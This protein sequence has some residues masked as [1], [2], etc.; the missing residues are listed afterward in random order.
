MKIL[1][2]GFLLLVPILFLFV[3][4]AFSSINDMV[5]PSD[6]KILGLTYKQW[7]PK[8]WQ[9][10]VSLPNLKNATSP[11]GET[12]AMHD[13]CF[14]NS[15][16]PVIFLANPIIGAYVFGNA[17]HT[18]EC[19]IPQNK[20]ILVDGIDEICSY[21]APKEN[22]P[23]QLIKT[24]HEL[25]DC[26]HARNPYASVTFTVDNESIKVPSEKNENGQSPYSITTDYFN[27]TI[28]KG[29]MVE[30]WGIGTYRSLLESKLI[31]LKPLPKG[32]HTIGIKTVQIT[33][34]EE[35]RLDLDMKYIMHV[36]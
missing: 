20:P 28:P 22:D 7:A 13:K 1:F 12:D 11:S 15:T 8:F 32:D 23:T 25:K 33:P 14:L 9:W 4:Q 34:N 17:A 21:N 29:S 24:D 2:L 5:Y 30:D 35:D 6:S 27:I 16:S 18:Y 36:K 3:N 31:I 19:T 10:W 26:V